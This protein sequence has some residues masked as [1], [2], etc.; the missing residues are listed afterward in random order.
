MIAAT[1]RVAGVI[2]SPIRHSLS[3][4][5]FNAAFAACGLDW[6]YAA[7]EVTEGEAPSAMAGV[8]SLALEGVSVTMPHKEAVIPALDDLDVAAAALGAVNCVVRRGSSLRGHNTDGAG[9]VDSLR[10]DESV[11][12]AGLRCTV[13]GAG[14]AGRAVAHALGAAGGIVTV[15]NR[16]PERAEAAAALAGPAARVGTVADV[17]GADLIVNATSVGMGADG[18]LPLD[19]TRLRDNQV[20]I[21]LVYHPARTPLLDAAEAAGARVIGGVGMLV[22][23][24][25]HAF[26]LWTGEA[27]PLEAMRHAAVAALAARAT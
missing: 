13:L 8:R 10:F 24:A 9:L 1:T 2:G 7:F 23:Q 14:G 15:V 26:Q 19:A 6:V 21:D 5:I 12:V 3:P 27:P 17:D 11:D 20:V 22:H 16:T 4:A 25:A 18:Q